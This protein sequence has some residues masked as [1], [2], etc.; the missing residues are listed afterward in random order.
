[1][2]NNNGM[3][4]LLVMV[5]SRPRYDVVV[6]VQKDSPVKDPAGEL[7]SAQYQPWVLEVRVWECMRAGASLS[8][9]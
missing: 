9:P 4:L 7:S 1:V 6:T 5:W 2:E 3:V 8:L